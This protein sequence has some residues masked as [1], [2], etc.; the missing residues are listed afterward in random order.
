VYTVV[1][2]SDGPSNDVIKTQVLHMYADFVNGVD[3]KGGIM[4]RLL[5]ENVV[6]LEQ[7]DKILEEKTRQAV[8]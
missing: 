1:C 4:D 8:F 7:Y 5:Q 2:L 3:P 6:T